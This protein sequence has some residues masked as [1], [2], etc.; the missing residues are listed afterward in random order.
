MSSDK[1]E[2]ER[3]QR[4]R[5]SQITSRDPGPSKI[6]GYDWQQHAQRGQ[7]IKASRKAKQKPLLIDLFLLLPHR[8]RGAII[9]ILLGAIPAAAGYLL[10]SDDMVML[11]IIPPIVAG[12]IGYVSGLVIEPEKSEWD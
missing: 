10:L 9:G 1:N 5:D 4:L 8:W 11:A 2:R 7:Q 3:L 12:V 6:R